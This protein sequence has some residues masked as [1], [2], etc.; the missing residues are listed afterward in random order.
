MRPEDFYAVYPSFREYATPELKQKHVRQFD[1]EFWQATD[2]RSDMS[3]LEIGCGAGL[4]LAYLE[5]KGVKDFT[6]LDLDAKIT[7]FIPAELL[8][9]VKIV[10]VWEYLERV[11]PHSVDRVA[12]FDVFEHFAPAEGV[13]LLKKISN[14]LKPGGRVV[15]RV[16]NAASPWGLQYQYHDLTHKT[17]YNTG[18]L[19][20]VALAAGFDTLSFFGQQKGHWFRRTREKMLHGLLSWM[21][22]E[23]PGI[24]SANFLAVLAPV[25]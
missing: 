12:M 11:P 10:D 24:W 2:A 22:T 8:A 6:G 18:S 25:K 20:Q 21:L 7:E 9:H 5:E 23:P 3:I 15:M 14:V 1:R 13:A 19:R 4:F 16:P 17:A